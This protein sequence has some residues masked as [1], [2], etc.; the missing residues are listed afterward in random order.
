V[1]H[2]VGN[3]TIAPVVTVTAI[4]FDTADERRRDPHHAFA[5][6][7]RPAAAVL[8][9]ERQG[10]RYTRKP[11]SK[12][13][14]ATIAA[15]VVLLLGATTLISL[16]KPLEI[17]VQPRDTRVTTPGTVLA[18]K[19]GEFLNV[20]TGK[21]VVRGEHEGYYPAQIT[22]DVQDSATPAAAPVARLRLAKLPG[23]L[24]IDTN[25]VA[26][27][28]SVDGVQTGKAPGDIES[29]SGLAHGHLARAALRRLRDE[30]RCR[31]SRQASGHHR[32][33][34]AFMGTLKV[35]AIPAG[36]QV[37]VD[38]KDAGTAPATIEADS[39]V[40]HVQVSFAGL[41][42]WESSVVIKAGETLGTSD[43]TRQPDA[44]LTLRSEPNGAEI[45]VAGTYRGRT[46]VKVD[47]PAGNTRENR[48][49]LHC[50]A[51]LAD[52]DSANT[53]F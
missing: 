36:S 32:S 34:A 26:A 21:H 3:D 48:S 35:S 4:D 25:G 53:D 40:R 8:T 7:S 9:A 14:I 42:T 6:G 47:L 15:A 30:H 22:V 49:H 41:K 23:K 19:S 39:G 28:V 37:F 45:T 18:F 50:R 2:L 20:L 10:S 33:H 31:R 38:G 16:L 24:R 5:A 12:K 43:H 46:P 1:L 52:P 27:S 29:A 17:D 44:E 11:L 51:N 13:W